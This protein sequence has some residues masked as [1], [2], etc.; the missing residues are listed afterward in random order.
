MWGR[1]QEAS[2]KLNF[3]SVAATGTPPGM[4]PGPPGPSKYLDELPNQVDACKAPGYRAKL[5]TPLHSGYDPST[6]SIDF[7]NTIE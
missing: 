3:A 7:A 2:G 6:V 5:Q 4:L 1:E